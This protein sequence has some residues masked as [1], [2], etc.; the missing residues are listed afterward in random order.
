MRT[1]QPPMKADERYMRPTFVLT[2]L[3]RK[4]SSRYSKERI[5]IKIPNKK[6]MELFMP[7]AAVF[8]A[9]NCCVINVPPAIIIPMNMPAS[10]FQSLFMDIFYHSN[11]IVCYNAF[12]ALL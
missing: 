11:K 9:M 7:H 2:K 5:K 10:L 8:S 4:L 12:H 6:R 1:I 3:P